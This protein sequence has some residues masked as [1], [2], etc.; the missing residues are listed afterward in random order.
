MQQDKTS[1]PTNQPRTGDPESYRADQASRLGAMT[2]EARDAEIKRLEATSP[3]Q[4]R[5]VEQAR[6]NALTP[7][8]RAANQR[9]VELTPEERAHQSAGAEHLQ[10]IGPGYILKG[11]VRHTHPSEGELGSLRGYT[12]AQI[13]AEHQ[14]RSGSRT[15]GDRNYVG[16]DRDAAA[17]RTTDGRLASEDRPANR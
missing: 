11:Q 14:S 2:P 13:Q 7:E 3:S 16:G 5:E 4:A 1:Y 8:E 17:A 9:R 6:I 12:D 15:R 10:W